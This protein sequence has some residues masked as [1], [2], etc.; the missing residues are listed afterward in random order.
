[1]FFNSKDDLL[2]KISYL[3]G[4]IVPKVFA[5]TPLSGAG[6]TEPAEPKNAAFQK[7]KPIAAGDMRRRVSPSI[8]KG[9][10]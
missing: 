4:V 6:R 7:D 5:M 1:M 10:P 9:L 2:G 3:S 8:S